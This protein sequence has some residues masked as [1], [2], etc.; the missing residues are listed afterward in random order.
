[1]K[2]ED[3]DIETISM[4]ISWGARAW[5]MSCMRLENIAPCKVEGG[6]MGGGGGCKLY[7]MR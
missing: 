3:L 7:E 4:M 1:M 5:V 2:E 6:G